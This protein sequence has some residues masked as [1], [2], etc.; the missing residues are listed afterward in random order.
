M[1]DD[2]RVNLREAWPMT[3]QHDKA[4]RWQFGLRSLV[5]AI[6]LVAFV[7][8]LTRSN[9]TDYQ[10]ESWPADVC[11]RFALIWFVVALILF[12]TAPLVRARAVQWLVALVAFGGLV[13]AVTNWGLAI[14]I[15]TAG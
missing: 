5:G 2:R 10:A 14:W 3:F 11:G 8:A 7:V 1:N 4:K 15:G 9:V 6:S 12:A 13:A